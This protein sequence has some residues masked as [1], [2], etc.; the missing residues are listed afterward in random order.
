MH[1]RVL[2]LSSHYRKQADFSW[3]AMDQAKANYERIAGWIENLKKI[4]SVGHPTSNWKS[5]VLSRFKSA[6]DDDLNTPLALSSLL[7]L[8]TETNKKMAENKLSA[9]KAAETLATFEKINKVFGLKFPE[10]ELEIPQDV[11][12]LADT[13]LEARKNKDFQK[14]DDLRKEIEK[15]GYIVEDSGESYKLKK[16]A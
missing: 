10:K 1:L 5:D 14:A 9:E 8:I 7:E 11:K 16:I 13:R 2:F 15:M 4:T 6:M 3:K 12:K